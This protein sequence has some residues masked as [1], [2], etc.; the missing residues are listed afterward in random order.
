MVIS[1]NFFRQVYYRQ[2]YN[3]VAQPAAGAARFPFL[4]EGLGG[5][6]PQQ[7]LQT[8]LQ[9]SPPLFFGKSINRGEISVVIWTDALWKQKSSGSA[10]QKKISIFDFRFCQGIYQSTSDFC[11]SISDFRFPIFD[12][13]FSI[14]DFRFPIFDF[15]F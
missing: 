13:R 2:M 5:R 10:T 9:I 8:F 3:T 15:R 6:A 7:I 1:I 11:L 14:F 4:H 12:F